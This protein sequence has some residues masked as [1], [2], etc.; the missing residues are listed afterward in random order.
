MTVTPL[1]PATAGNPA[2]GG[3]VEFTPGAR[4][5]WHSHPAGQTLVVTAGVGWVQQE[6]KDR[7]V[8]RAGDVVTI[9]PGVKHWHGASA[10]NSMTHIAITPAV[11]GKNADWMEPVSDAQFDAEGAAR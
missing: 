8:I 1:Y 7:I 9:P 11:D 6:S 5:N 4:A 3:L 2:G 10:A